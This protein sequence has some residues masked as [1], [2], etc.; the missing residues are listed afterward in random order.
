MSAANAKTDS[1]RL[2][3]K[4]TKDQGLAWVAAWLGWTLAAFDFAIILLLMVPIS[5]DFG[6]P[7]TSLPAGIWA[8]RYR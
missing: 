2:W 8:S 5:K 6:V 1:I 4:P 7:L 3:K